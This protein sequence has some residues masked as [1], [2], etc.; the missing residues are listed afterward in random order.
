MTIMDTIRAR[1]S[2]REYYPTPIEDKLIQQLESLIEECQAQS[3]LNIQLVSNNPEA[4]HLVASFGLVRGAQSHIAFVTTGKDQ[5]EAIGYWG[6]KIVLAAQEM[7]L[8][9]CW[10]GIISRKKSKAVR[11]DGEKLRLGI[12]IGY[13]KTQGRTR[14][15]KNAAELTDIKCAE[16]PGWFETAVEAAQ[17]SPTAVNNQHFKIT[18]HEDGEGVS[19]KAPISGYDQI[20]LGIVKYNFEAAANECEAKWYWV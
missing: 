6:Q 13:G 18:L 2:V 16:V 3:G 17:L 11:L 1:H 8:N 19:I 9:T 7:G 20:D 12:A 14:P 15:T 5:D 10:T 4:Y